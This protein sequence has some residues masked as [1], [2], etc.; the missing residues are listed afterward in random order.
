MAT[1][2]IGTKRRAPMLASML[3]LCFE[4]ITAVDIAEK[5]GIRVNVVRTIMRHFYELRLVHIGGWTKSGFHRPPAVMWKA[6]AGEDVPRPVGSWLRVQFKARQ[7]LPHT[8]KGPGIETIAFAHAIR[9]LTS[10]PVS[11]KQL[12][13]ETGW[14][15][16]TVGRFLRHCRRIKLVH[17]A[18]WT[19][20]PH[21]CGMWAPMYSLGDGADAP[22]PKPIPRRE[23]ERRYQQARRQ[24]LRDARMAHALAANASIFAQRE[25]CIRIVE[26][27][28][29]ARTERTGD[30]A[31]C[32]PQ[33][34]AKA[35]GV[36]ADPSSG[37]VMVAWARAVLAEAA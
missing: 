4:P 30:D 13:E 2:K 25:L 6:G 18:D 26:P 11:A 23:I 1:R 17:I 37:P 32:M 21:N 14:A 34:I 35:R 20:G 8:G 31:P 10:E 29:P 15:H 33:T 7:Q 36:L 24:R 9:A 12:A 19:R 22:K 27:E 3:R 5:I 28:Q 16:S